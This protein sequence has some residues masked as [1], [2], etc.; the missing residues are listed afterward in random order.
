ME[1]VLNNYLRGK[2]HGKT[3]TVEIDPPTRAIK[4]Y[5]EETC[6]A[7]EMIWAQKQGPLY[8]CYSGGLDSEYVL[9]VVR[10]L[11]MQV[12]PVIMRTA[13][14]DHETRYAFEYCKSYNI[15]PTVIDL[16]YDKFIE[17]G[18]FLEI[19]TSI[20]CAA[21]QIPCNMWLASQLDGTV[22][23]GNDPP[24]MKK[25]ADGLWYLDEEEIIHSQF[26]YFKKYKV[27]GTPFL[28]SYTPELMLSFLLDP[29]MVS[30]ANNRIPGK[31][32]TNSTKVQ[33]FNNNKGAFSLV[34]RVKQ[35]GYEHVETSAIFNHPDIQTVVSW[36]DKWLGS[37]DHQYH[38]V[39]ER[40]SN[41]KTSK[42]KHSGD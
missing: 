31:L 1:L 28:L 23:T 14:N 10:H 37:S 4:S 38:K 20:K 40:L 36:K 35:H 42:E 16:D 3:W 2:G 8:L 30:L 7:A 18:K 34:N 39:V 21:F 27:H 5:F 13:Y 41:N 17:S 25:K 12:I 24:H 32:G 19:A 26:A 9:S 22:I 6:I 11:G 29:T 15:T 33:V